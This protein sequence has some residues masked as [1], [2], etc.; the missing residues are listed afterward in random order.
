MIMNSLKT[1]LLFFGLLALSACAST[2]FYHKNFMRG[3]VVSVNGAEAVVCIGSYDKKL[4]GKTLNV[5][6]IE[7]D[8]NT[9]EGEEGFYLVSVGTLEITS[10]INEH[11]ARARIKN[12]EVTKNNM[13]KLSR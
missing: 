11:F 2:P 12:G 9:A 3:Q 5:S 10:I 1:A 6:K 4:L 7:Y 13:V 8:Y